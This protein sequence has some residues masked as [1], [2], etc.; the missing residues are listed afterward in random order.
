MLR[1]IMIMLV[2][3]LSLLS[4]GKKSDVVEI[5]DWNFGGRPHLMVWLRQRAVSFEQTHPGIKIIQNDKSWNMIREILYASFTTGTGPDVVNT[6]AN[7]AAEF[8]EAGYY[9]PINKFPDFE[10]VRA[11]FLPEAFASTEYKGNS[12]GLPSSAIA[13]ALV[14]NKEMFDAE[15]IAPPKTWSE[16]RAAAKRLTKDT[17]G[18]GEVD[19]YGL[20]LMGGDKG[21]FAYRMVPF[22]YKAGVNFMSDD[23]SKIEFNSSMGVETIALFARM[24]QEDHSITPGFL[25]YGPTETNDMLCG[26][27][28]AMAIEGPWVRGMVGAKNP[29][30]KLVIV[31]VPVPDAMIDRYDTAPTLQDMVMYSVNA[32]SKN[33]DAAWEFIKYLRSEE[34]DM[35]WVRLDMGG[36]AVTNAALASPEAQKVEDLSMFIRELKHA[37]PFPPHPKVIAVASNTFTPFCQKAI[38]G[39]MTPQAALDQA[40]REALRTIEG[41]E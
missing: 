35:D 15:G 40:A 17:N 22:F 29:S 13:F 36:M 28:A 6:H 26:N 5:Q 20:V 19:Q 27:K 21:G 41:K 18:D 24:Y 31:P 34:A 9:Y 10:K 39:D 25:A 16:F 33:L 23:L 38:V 1:T 32:H 8:G 37:R 3:S 4:C 7:Y 30:A 14:C 12:Y 11:T 2:L